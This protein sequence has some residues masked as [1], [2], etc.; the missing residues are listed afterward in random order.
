MDTPSLPSGEKDKDSYTSFSIK[1]TSVNDTPSK[2][3]FI[4][5]I[6]KFVRKPQTLISIN[7][8]EPLKYLSFG[9][10]TN[11]KQNFVNENSLISMSKNDKNRSNVAKSVEK[12]R[13][14]NTMQDSI[15]EFLEETKSIEEDLKRLK[16][17]SAEKKYMSYATAPRAPR[18]NKTVGN[19]LERGLIDFPVLRPIDISKP[20]Y[21]F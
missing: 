8:D 4:T 16:Q 14:Q 5:R 20:L 11:T 9:S 3:L 7:I 15:Q 10:K 19:S 18:A 1:N 2:W 6:Y 12:Q 17:L 13:M 21:D